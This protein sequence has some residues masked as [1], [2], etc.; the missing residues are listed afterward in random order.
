MNKDAPSKITPEKIVSIALTFSDSLKIAKKAG[1]SRNEAILKANALTAEAIGVD[2]FN[3]LKMDPPRVVLDRNSYPEEIEI[4]YETLDLLLASGE[5]LDHG[6]KIDVLW[7][8]MPTALKSIEA[9][10]GHSFNPSTLYPQLKISD[11]YIDQKNN[12]RSRI[13][14]K[15]VHA[16]EFRRPQPL[17]CADDQTKEGKP[18]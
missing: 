12:K 4:F 8:H 16:W 18:S 3:L 15:Q 6:D 2:V 7:I 9:H 14:R 17:D 5:V 11:R 10:L 1:L 13:F